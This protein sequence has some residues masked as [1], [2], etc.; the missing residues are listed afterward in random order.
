VVVL[1][2]MAGRQ[3]AEHYLQLLAGEPASVCTAAER[4]ALVSRR[5]RRAAR[6]YA[7]D[8]Y[9]GRAAREVRALQAA[10]ARLAVEL[11]RGGPADDRLRDRVL[12]HRARMRRLG[13]PEA[14]A[15]PGAVP[16]PWLLMFVSASIV[17]MCALFVWALLA[18]GAG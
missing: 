18:L 14:A 8:R 10:Q 17:G 13:H 3:E 9:G 2:R 6:R 5:R 11:S 15:P 4:A 16:P 7:L 12:R 1:G